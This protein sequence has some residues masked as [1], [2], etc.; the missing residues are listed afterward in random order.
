MP[1][2]CKRPLAALAMLL[3]LAASFHAGRQS[4]PTLA[5]KLDNARVTVTES[6]TPAGGARAS[7]VRGTDQIIVFLDAAQYEAVDAAG[8][9]TARSRQSGDVVWHARG[10]VAP[11]LVNKGAAYRNLI[12]AIK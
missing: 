2:K 12:I 5:V 8:N 1:E 4:A 10:E 3:A 9:A 11:R 6:V 7:Y